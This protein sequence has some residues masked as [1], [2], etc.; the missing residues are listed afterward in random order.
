MC[1]ITST[2]PNCLHAEEAVAQWR[3]YTVTSTIT[4]RHWLDAR[5]LQY[6]ESF[7][8]RIKIS[9]KAILRFDNCSTCFDKTVV[10]FPS[11]KY[12]CVAL[13]YLFGK[14][15]WKLCDWSHCDVINGCLSPAIGQKRSRVKT[16]SVQKVPQ[17][18]VKVG[19][20]TDSQKLLTHRNTHKQN[21]TS[22]TRL[23]IANCSLFTSNSLQQ[24][25]ITYT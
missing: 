2:V 12:S 23:P 25:H 10:L 17:S 5:K 6:N 1:C 7:C 11:N 24:Q 16:L 22:T 4:M 19:T 14:W 8:A 20:V 18:E 13:T 3:H 15:D 21:H 9:F